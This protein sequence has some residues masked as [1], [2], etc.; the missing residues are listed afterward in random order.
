MSVLLVSKMGRRGECLP[1]TLLTVGSLASL[2]ANIAV[3][4]P[5]VISRLIA[6]WPS[7]AFVGA[8]HLLQGQL[9]MYRTAPLARHGVSDGNPQRHSSRTETRNRGF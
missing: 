4:D 2:A 8:Y 7:F 5:K 6:A 1:W 9:R 3:A